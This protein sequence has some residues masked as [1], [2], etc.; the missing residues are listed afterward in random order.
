[1][2]RA[3]N[4]MKNSMSRALVPFFAWLPARRPREVE[5]L[6]PAPS[7]PGARGPGYTSEAPDGAKFGLVK[8]ETYLRDTDQVK[9]YLPDILGRALARIWIDRGFRD[10]FQADP[11]GT[12]AQYNVFLPE[13]ID[14][15]F[16]TEGVTRPRIVVYERRRSGPR[17]RLLYLQLVMMAGT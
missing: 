6:P 8:Q 12:M 2:L 16:V 11:I 9:R 1:M 15:E 14:V 7:A 10:N 13:A 3:G 4:A 5:V 17:R